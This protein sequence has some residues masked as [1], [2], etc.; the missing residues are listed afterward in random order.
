MSGRMMTVMATNAI[1]TRPWKKP[2]TAFI[3]VLGTTSQKYASSRYVA[4]SN[5]AMNLSALALRSSSLLWSSAK[6]GTARG[7]RGAQSVLWRGERDDH[8]PASGDR[9]GR[10]PGRASGAGRHRRWRPRPLRALREEGRRDPGVHHRGGDHRVVREEVGAHARPVALPDLPDVRGT[11]ERRLDPLTH[12]RSGS[13]A[14][15]R[16]SSTSGVCGGWRYT[17]PRSRP[18]SP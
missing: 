5:R 6:S 4:V 15:A 10:D 13:N 7:Y 16:S 3:P 18:A 8:R 11:Q 14:L 12:D 1:Q 17:M 9:A 2:T